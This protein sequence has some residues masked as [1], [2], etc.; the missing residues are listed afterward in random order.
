MDASINDVSP[1]T[2]AVGPSVKDEVK[3]FTL[4][5]PAAPYFEGEQDESLGLTK[6]RSMSELLTGNRYTIHALICE[7]IDK[8]NERGYVLPFP[9]LFTIPPRTSMERIDMR[10]NQRQIDI[11]DELRLSLKPRPGIID[12]REYYSRTD[13]MRELLK[14]ELQRVQEVFNF[15][16]RR[17]VHGPSDK[18]D[19][20]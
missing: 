6:L 13:V 5:L 19:V 15:R 10:L 20:R 14:F 16:W 3:H 18:E 12:I 7:I 4:R 2:R 1:P 9:K 11:I 8:A 17:V